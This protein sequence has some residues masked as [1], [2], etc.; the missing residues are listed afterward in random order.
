MDERIEVKD[1]EDWRDWLA[2]NF[3][4]KNGVWL[5]FQRKQWSEKGI[6]LDEAVEEAICFGWID[7]KLRKLDEIRYVL[8]FSPRKPK[9][10]WSKINKDRAEMLIKAGR[11]APSG[12]ATIEQAKSSGTWHSAYTNKAKDDVPADLEAALKDSMHAWANFQK[13]ANSYRNMYIGWIN[14]SKTSETRS[15]RIQKVVEQSR[16][17]KKTVLQ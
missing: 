11:M 16:L 3:D 10:V 1:R 8:R 2:Q 17:N 5:T 6:R 15:K 7:G 9:S 4:K 14:A 12:L 13:F